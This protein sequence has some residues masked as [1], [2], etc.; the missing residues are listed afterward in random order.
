MLIL[1]L[2][3]IT[4]LYRTNIINLISEIGYSTDIQKPTLNRYQFSDIGRILDV[5]R[6]FFTDI[7]DILVLY[8]KKQ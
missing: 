5:Y 1:L 2:V 3:K 4:M 6:H 7:G 8:D